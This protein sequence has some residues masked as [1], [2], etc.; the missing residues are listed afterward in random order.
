MDSEN[1]E[2]EK[3]IKINKI[4]LGS[5]DDIK[6]SVKK[7]KYEKIKSLVHDYLIEYCHHIMVDD[8]IDIDPEKSKY[9]RYCEK[10]ELT[11]QVKKINN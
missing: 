8:W 11:F 10:C 3:M 1:D 5:P 2:L 6:N 7:E 4:L 9:I